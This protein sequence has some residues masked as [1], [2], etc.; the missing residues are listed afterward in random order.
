MN[1]TYVD[2]REVDANRKR[3]G[4]VIQ[5]KT[6]KAAVVLLSLRKKKKKKI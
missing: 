3:S 1:D 5:K 4:S 6:E 2:S